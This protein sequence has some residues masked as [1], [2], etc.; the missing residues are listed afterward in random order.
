MRFARKNLNNG[1]ILKCDEDKK[2]YCRHENPSYLALV[3]IKKHRN[4]RKRLKIRP[5]SK[6]G[7][8]RASVNISLYLDTLPFARVGHQK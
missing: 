6:L 5:D 4:P 1:A 3:L 2:S 7:L 8:K